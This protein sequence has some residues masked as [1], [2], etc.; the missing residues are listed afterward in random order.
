MRYCF[1]IVI[2]FLLSCAKEQ[3][4]DPPSDNTNELYFPPVG[5]EDW[6]TT[7]PAEL[8]WDQDKLGDLLEFL[9]DNDTRAFIILKDGKIVVEEYFG[10]SLLG[11]PFTKDSQWY[12]ASAGKTLTSF[13]VGQAQT[14]GHLSIEDPSSQYLGKGW[15]SMTEDRESKIKV[16]HQLTMTT[17]LN[18]RGVNTD[19]T[20][21]RC[22]TYL[23][24]PEDRWAYHNAPYTLLDGV[25]SGSTE[26]DFDS[27]F[28]ENL[29][30][31]IGME[32]NWTYLDFN[33]VYFSKARSMARFGLLILNGGKWEEEELIDP[34]FMS[35]SINSSQEINPAYGYLW[36]LNGKSS[37]MY[38]GLQVS[39]NRSLTPSAPSDMYAA[40]GKNGQLLNI[41]P[42]QNLIVLRMGDNPDAS[43]VPVNFQDK[44]WEYIFDIAF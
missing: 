36:W 43:L 38:P 23:E 27:Y 14:Q 39:L 37:V 34:S 28:E 6:E 41:V 13:L 25:V 8:D 2:V 5:Q 16:R 4:D 17:G 22:L 21:S 11:L 40:M 12:W 20:E 1:F 33:H 44:M 10:K 29:K 26:M 31:P 7:S 18:D 42:S 35:E 32:G 19:C 3:V 30:H 9:G 15:T 24:D